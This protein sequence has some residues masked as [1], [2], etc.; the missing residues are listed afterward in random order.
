MSKHPDIPVVC[1]L[2]GTRM[3]AIA[4]QIGKGLQCPDC[5][6]VNVV[7]AP[8]IKKK[9]QPVAVAVGD[10]Y[11]LQ[12]DPTEIV[13]FTC[14]SCHDAIKA[15][16]E[17]AGRKVRCPNCETVN[18]V[19]RPKG[20]DAGGI[21]LQVA[22]GVA[23]NPTKKQIADRIMARAREEMAQKEEEFEPPEIPV[24]PFLDGVFSFPFYGNVM[25]MW[26]GLA[27]CM[28]AM[29]TLLAFSIDMMKSQSYEMGTGLFLGLG[30][31]VVF[32][33]TIYVFPT[34][35]FRITES[36]ATGYDKVE[37][38]ADDFFDRLLVLF[39][40][41][42][43]IGFGSIPG[44]A[45]ASAVG[46]PKGLGFITAFGL[47]PIFLLSMLETTSPFNFFSERI[48]NSFSIAPGSWVMFYCVTVPMM[49][50]VFLLFI[51]MIL[52]EQI[53]AA[54]AVAA[55]P[56]PIVSV[57]YFRMMGRLALLIGQAEIMQGVDG[58]QADG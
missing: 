36:T 56:I 31:G 5:H 35:F 46:V 20:P 38:A 26:I 19:P 47:F 7:K 1:T 45:L 6:T 11:R 8:V 33:F 40:L 27:F 10:G 3:Y 41:F 53:G 22:D 29:G 55:I 15:K 16:G 54:I 34:K 23:A 30:F 50:G 13:E 4:A 49:V 12:E 18:V 51:V 43:A 24:Q 57:I 52:N 37:F 44:I 32:A 48:R 21:A 28:A 2:C 58:L 25:V 39:L 42:N 14:T 9:P 17:Y